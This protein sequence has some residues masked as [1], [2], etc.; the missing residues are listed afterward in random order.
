MRQGQKRGDQVGASG[1]LVSWTGFGGELDQ[2][3]LKGWEPCS[4]TEA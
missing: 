2:G 4:N 3:L 1:G